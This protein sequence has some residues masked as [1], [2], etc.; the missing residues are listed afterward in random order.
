M[1]FATPAVEVDAQAADH[2]QRRWDSQGSRSGDWFRGRQAPPSPQVL[3]TSFLETRLHLIPAASDDVVFGG[4]EIPAFDLG[5]PA[6]AAEVGIDERVYQLGLED[7]HTGSRQRQQADHVQAG[8]HRKRGSVVGVFLDSHAEHGNLRRALQHAEDRQPQG[9]GQRS[10]IM[11]SV[12]ILPRTMR[13]WVA[14]S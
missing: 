12:G 9:T 4:R 3:V 7:Q 13:A 14:K 1:D 8:G 11:S 2:H 10:L 5:V 6:I